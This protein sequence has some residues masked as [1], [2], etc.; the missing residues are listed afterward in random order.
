M[1]VFSRIAGIVFFTLALTGCGGGSSETPPD[2]TQDSIASSTMTAIRDVLQRVEDCPNGG[3]EIDI[4]IDANG[5]GVLSSSEI[6]RTETICN[7]IDGQNGLDGQDGSPGA[8]GAD[9][10]NGSDGIDGADGLDGLTAL[11]RLLDE[12]AGDNCAK[13]GYLIQSGLDF[14]A[15]AQ[16]DSNEVSDSRYICN[17]ADATAPVYVA[18][19]RSTISGNIN[20]PNASNIFKKPAGKRATAQKVTS[21]QGGLWLSPNSILSAIQTDQGAANLDPNPGDKGISPPAIKPIKVPVDAAGNFSVEVPAGTDYTL[22]AVSN[23]GAQGT[24]ISDIAVEPGSSASLTIEQADLSAVGSLRLKV[25]DLANA[26]PIVGAEVVLLAT[27]ATTTTEA[28]GSAGFDSLPEGTYAISVTAAGYISQYETL[29]ISAASQTDIGNVQLNSQ[30]GTASGQI[31]VFGLDNLSNIP[32]YARSLDGDVF[33]TLTNSS[34][35][36]SFNALPV[37]EGYS[38]IAIAND[39][40]S[41]KVDNITITTGNHANIGQIT[42]TPTLTPVGSIT[43]YAWYSERSGRPEHAG[44]IVSVE[45]T[46]KEGITARDGA[47]VINGLPS[48]SYT[49]NYTDSNHETVTRS[50]QV[51]ASAATNLSPVTLTALTGTLSGSVLDDQGNT[52]ASAR[53]LLR[54]QGLL[55]L[56]DSNGAFSF[57]DAPA[58]DYTLEISK[59]GYQTRVQS[60]SVP[61]NAS[62][63]L[64]ALELLAYRFSGKVLLEGQTDHAG[65]LLSISGSGQTV[66]SDSSGAFEFIGIPAGSYQLQLSRAG[67]Q[68]QSQTILIPEGQTSYALNYDLAMTPTQ[69]VIEGVATLGG[70]VNHAGILVRLLGTAYE[71]YTDASGRWSMTVSTGN[72]GDGIEYSRPLFGTAVSAETVTVVDN[73]SYNAAPVNLNQQAVSTSISV[74]A[75]NGCTD[76]LQVRFVGLSAGNNSVD[77]TADVVAGQISGIDLPFGDYN[78]TASCRLAG[79]ESVTRLVTIE[80]NSLLDTTLDAI[81]LRVRYVNIN[82]GAAITNNPAV[83][84]E[85]GATDAAE[86]RVLE[87]S[88]DSGFI[89]FNA[90]HALTLSAGDGDK[91]VTV[92]FRDGSGA[93]LPSVNAVITLDT[94]INVASFT[95]SGASTRGDELLLTLDIGETGA[96]ITAD[97]PNQINTLSLNDNG[98]LGDPVAGDGVYGRRYLIDN[99]KDTDAPVV[100]HI[101]DRAGNT[102]DTQTA[103]NLQL[104]TAP[105]ILN[106]NISSDIAAGEM[107]IQFTTD[108]DT[109]TVVDYG[110]AFTNLA[111]NAVV[112]ASATLVHSV[113]LSG[114]PSDAITYL[115]ITATDGSGNVSTLQSQGKLA[116]TAMTGLQT[117]VGNGEIAVIWPPKVSLRGYSYHV[118]RSTD[119]VSYN[120]ITDTPIYASHYLDQ[121]LVNGQTLY[122]KVSVLDE[123][124]N[125]SVLS[126]AVSAAADGNLNGPTVIDGGFIEGGEVVW[127]PSLSPYQITARTELRKH[128]RLRMLP[129]VTLELNLN[130]FVYI[131][132]ELWLLGE[133]GNEVTIRAMG[134]TNEFRTG[135]EDP[136]NA[137][138]TY[139]GQKCLG[140]TVVMV[141]GYPL[142]GSAMR[143]V[144]I[145]GPVYI[146]LAQGGGIDVDHLQFTNTDA[147]QVG[148]ILTNKITNSSFTGNIYI[149]TDYLF[150]SVIDLTLSSKTS[151]VINRSGRNLDIKVDGPTDAYGPTYFSADSLSDSTIVITGSVSILGHSLNNTVTL[152]GDGSY[153]GEY[154]QNNRITLCDTCTATG[155]NAVATYWGTDQWSDIEARLGDAVENLLPIVS[156]P[157]LFNTDRDGDTVPDYLDYDNDNDGYSDLQEIQ[158]S[159]PALGIVYDPWDAT[160]H[161]DPASTD[162]DADMDGIRDSDDPDDDND[163]LTDA[164]ELT[165]GT[166]PFM[167]DSDG[168]RAPDQTEIAYGY[169]PLD[170]NNYPLTNWPKASDFAPM[171]VDERNVNASGDVIVGGA[172]YSP[173]FNL[174]PGTRVLFDNKSTLYN[175]DLVSSGIVIDKYTG[176]S[177]SLT[178]RDS[179]IYNLAINTLS[180]SMQGNPFVER[181]TADAG[182]TMNNGWLLDSSVTDTNAQIGTSYVSHSVI[183]NTG[184]VGGS[185]IERSRIISS[186]LGM[187]GSIARNSVFEIGTNGYIRWQSGVTNPVIWENNL[188]TQTGTNTSFNISGIT[189]RD[190]DIVLPDLRTDTNPSWTLFRADNVAFDIQGSVLDTGFGNPVDLLGDGVTDT[191]IEFTNSLG[192]S[193]SIF[194]DALNN[195]RTTRIFPGGESDLWDP[196]GVGA[197]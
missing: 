159:F 60:I 119:G 196:S 162:P 168:D 6:S 131:A 187:D 178:L 78:L 144:N 95:A 189:L 41:S 111:S 43:G 93:A 124:G 156:G 89:A 16:L 31:E 186:G 190:S 180:V 151:F 165:Y 136:C 39:F 55:T 18:S 106:L 194:V 133:P 167:D 24:Q 141:K 77:V 153:T 115:Q 161:P 193:Q 192:T 62:A 57:V 37:G 64:G 38:F 70:Q 61:R 90:S 26:Q 166:D 121:G 183:G 21:Q 101:T 179:K 40:R 54:E 155:T 2:D 122:Y 137:A 36:F 88:T 58:G 76:D 19:Q 197:F 142:T 56:S 25:I 103:A 15:N 195:P 99:S 102:L 98:I 85:I 130:D 86:M 176:G 59:E 104:N 149:N 75:V 49:V 4:G 129:G 177:S 83:T 128:T 154:N 82:G 63:N 174:P 109:T 172:L 147:S 42:L 175:L 34:G 169:D 33:A 66:Q 51:V 138:Y 146:S 158:E 30:K 152:I 46:D 188:I 71:A 105:Q 28:D 143:H 120:R 7:G 48:G 118:Y 3:V 96:T 27:G 52:V 13:G 107:T 72:Y 163:G 182:L 171:I 87:G 135:G 12:A 23:D 10:T 125:E 32:V 97:I 150:D 35:I 91:T 44:I 9:G 29:I 47:F 100:A 108:E 148:G 80:D 68:A 145:G 140:E 8:A 160:S 79:W 139:P 110:D 50:V 22:V 45:G 114:L 1:E 5:D 191:A 14:N 53:L 94:S 17:G 157:D 69:G 184:N 185:F 126:D 113:T 65:V 92:E 123:N 74:S 81:A 132:G 173:Q 73:G 11:V 164:Q 134:A 84:L 170:R 112:S 67:Y 117:F 116:P 20:I 181:F 127:L